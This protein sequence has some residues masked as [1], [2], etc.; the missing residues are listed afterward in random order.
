M[1]LTPVGPQSGFGRL[2]SPAPGA[3][4]GRYV[5]VTGIL[6]DV[7]MG[8]V[9]YLVHR[10]EPGGVYWP[11][12]PY[13]RPGTDGHFAV[14][15]PDGGSTGQMVISLVLVPI[16]TTLLF[17]KRTMLGLHTGDWTG[18]DPHEYPVY[19]LD[20]IILKHDLRVAEEPDDGNEP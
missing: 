14:R 8:Y 15:N 3:V 17:D 13:L 5:R 10:L 19:E 6:Q 1:S 11:K 9:G 4:T 2:T 7:P 20:A 16:L 12:R 18:I